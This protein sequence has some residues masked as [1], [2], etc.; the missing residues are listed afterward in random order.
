MS[1][2]LTLDQG[3]PIAVISEAEEAGDALY[4]GTDPNHLPR[5]PPANTVTLRSRFSTW[6]RGSG[7][8]GGTNTQCTV[9][10]AL[11]LDKWK[12]LFFHLTFGNLG[13]WK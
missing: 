1:V 12:I 3:H 9:P 4:R 5:A 7:L 11:F 13:P 10:A 6:I 2:T 8:G